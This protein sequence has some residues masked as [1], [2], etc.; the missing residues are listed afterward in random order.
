MTILRTQD[1]DIGTWNPERFRAKWIPVRVK[2][3]RQNKRLW[4]DGHRESGLVKPLRRAWTADENERLKALVAQDV[5]VVRVAAAFERSMI[6]VRNQARKLGT[7][8][9]SMRAFRRKWADT[10]SSHWRP[11]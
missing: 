1:R 3:T 10:S 2:K 5:S 9:P 4:F 11:G 7:P 6:S 8:F